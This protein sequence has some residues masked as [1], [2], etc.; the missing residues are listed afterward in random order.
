MSEL[1]GADNE[2][3]HWANDLRVVFGIFVGL[4]VIMICLALWAYS[5]STEQP[6]VQDPSVLSNKR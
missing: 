6:V 4:P 2:P 1:H 5:A 3:R